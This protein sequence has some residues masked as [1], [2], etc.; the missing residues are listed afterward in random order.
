MRLERN[1]IGYRLK[2]STILDIKPVDYLGTSSK[3][4][5]PAI[6]VERTFSSSS[7]KIKSASAPKFKV[8]LLCS[9]PKER[10]GWSE[11]ASKAYSV[12]QSITVEYCIINS[13]C[14]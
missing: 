7:S 13:F 4:F 6:Q 9:I 3:T 12:E 1:V 5:S 11:A 2:A 8:P 14:G 10:A